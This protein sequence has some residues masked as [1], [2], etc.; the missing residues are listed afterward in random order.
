MGFSALFTTISPQQTRVGLHVL[1]HCSCVTVL[2]FHSEGCKWCMR[3]IL[4]NHIAC[5][6]SLSTTRA[7]VRI[8]RKDLTPPYM[9][10]G[11][12]DDCR[13]WLYDCRHDT[14]TVILISLEAAVFLIYFAL[15]FY[16]LGRAYA[17]LR[18]RNYRRALL[19]R[20][21]I[22]AWQR[23]SADPLHLSF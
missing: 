10:A 8:C 6:L 19:L 20:A 4:S 3:D 1:D 18:T 2:P 21:E 22:H 15:F 12:A 9:P 14:L 13:L 7:L 5:T 23:R 17:Q 11:T 16:Y